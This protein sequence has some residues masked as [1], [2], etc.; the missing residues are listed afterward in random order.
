VFFTGLSC[1][2]WPNPANNRSD[3]KRPANSFEEEILIS[4]ISRG[5]AM[6]QIKASGCVRHRASCLAMRVTQ[7]LLSELGLG[8]SAGAI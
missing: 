2:T 4:K 6:I 5:D 3:K 7:N 1:I 8:I